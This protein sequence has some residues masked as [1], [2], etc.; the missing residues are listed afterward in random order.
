MSLPLVSSTAYRALTA[1]VAAT[2]VHHLVLRKGEWHL[3]A[4]SIIET[5]LGSVVVIYA[6]EVALCGLKA[7]MINTLAFVASFTLALLL[8]IGAYRLFFH[9]LGSF[10]GP[11]LLALSK[12]WH[13]VECFPGSQNHLFL[14]RLRK[15]Y[16]DFVRTG[17]TE[18]T[19]FDPEA[20]VAVDGPRS[21]TTRSDLYD[22]LQP[23]VGLAHMRDQDAHD[24]RRRLWVQAVSAKNL[25]TYERH[26]ADHAATL[27]KVVRAQADAA[28]NVSFRD[29]AC[30]FAFD[31]MGMFLMS[32]SFDMIRDQSDHWVVDKMRRALTMLG[33][34]QYV[35]WTSQLGFKYGRGLSLVRDYHATMR[36]C[37]DRM[38][39]CADGKHG[40]AVNIGSYLV[41][42]SVRNGTV[43]QDRNLLM[44]EGIIG[45]VAGR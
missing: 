24:K 26:I 20:L 13:A 35:P 45:I 19:I 34:C 2:S 42:D 10:P 14:E 16:G 4:T 8:S 40:D 41:A 30:W 21:K 12:L 5:W 33:L 37:G 28:A 31:N 3:W 6:I 22:L 32:E 36:W 43:E 1:V 17:P 39:D 23:A 44:G 38:K 29:L 11:K 27:E 15:E 7:A 18:V 9:R 25:P